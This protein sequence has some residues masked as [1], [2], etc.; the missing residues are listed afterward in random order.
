M[1]VSGSGKTTIASMLAHRLD[2]IF[3]DADWFHPQSNIDKMRNGM[4]LTDADRRPWLRAIASWIE[5]A[6]RSGLQ[7]VIACSAL[8]RSYRDILVC[9]HSDVVIVYLKGDRDL[10]ARRLMLRAGHFM[11][12]TL[13][14]SQ[15]SA[16]EEPSPD[17]KPIVVSIDAPLRQIVDQ[18]LV[19]LRLHRGRA[20]TLSRG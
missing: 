15:F 16:L 14:D 13:L 8:K 9:N 2:F 1:G 11:P 12:P 6:R 7:T 4:A 18:I 5:Q 20:Q 17:E 10:I 3:Q 19:E